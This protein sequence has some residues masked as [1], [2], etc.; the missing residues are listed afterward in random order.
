M[1]VSQENSLPSWFLSWAIQILSLVSFVVLIPLIKDNYSA[2]TYDLWIFINTI[3]VF[4]IVFETSL[5]GPVTRILSY[6]YRG[7]EIFDA[8]GT[9]LIS[10][11]TFNQA[12]SSL[13]FFYFAIAGLASLTVVILAK[14][15]GS[16]FEPSQ[17]LMAKMFSL[18]AFFQVLASISKGM[19]IARMK[20]AQQRLLQL[21]IYSIRLG[22]AALVVS[23]SLP[24][25]LVIGIFVLS[26]I[27]ELFL[28]TRYSSFKFETPPTSDILFIVMENFRKTLPLKL[29]VTLTNFSTSLIIGLTSLTNL[30]VYILTFRVFYMIG[31]IANVPLTL[32]LPS[33]YREVIRSSTQYPLNWLNYY[34]VT[35]ALYCVGSAVFVT[36]IFYFPK[37]LG[38][39]LSV[40][41]LDDFKSVLLMLLFCLLECNRVVFVQLCEASNRVQ[42]TAFYVLAALVSITAQIC[43]ARLSTEPS[44]FD[45]LLIQFIIASVMVFWLHPMRFFDI[46][47]QGQK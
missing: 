8:E 20:I 18:V 1:V 25:M 41:F 11:C 15:F 44:L 30:S 28:Y 40:Y 2:A 14:V 42:Y 26:A 7:N 19:M 43:Y 12:A 35:I 3:I 5:I 6:L 38:P 13:L 34:A 27:C 32:S 45:F 47:R 39:D 21:I 16:H 37:D 4:G 46:T 9:K 36:A 17:L 22:V 29:S 24:F 33:I 23:M 31:S 10:S